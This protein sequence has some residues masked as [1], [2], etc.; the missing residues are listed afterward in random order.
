[1]PKPKQQPDNDQISIDDPN[2]PDVV[3][4]SS[5]EPAEECPIG[6]HWNGRECV[7]DDLQPQQ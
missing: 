7:Q 6:T 5:A 2:E 3:A 1:M 4:Y